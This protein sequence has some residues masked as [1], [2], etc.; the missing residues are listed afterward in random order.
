[1]TD[2]HGQTRANLKQAN[3]VG[4][5]VDRDG[6]G[7]LLVVGGEVHVKVQNRPDTCTLQGSD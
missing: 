1:M 3:R 4:G 6:V 5:V 2:K 7:Q